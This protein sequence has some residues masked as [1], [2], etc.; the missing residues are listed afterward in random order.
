MLFFGRPLSLLENKHPI[1]QRNIPIPLAFLDTLSYTPIIS[2]GHKWLGF[3]L[4]L[5]YPFRESLPKATPFLQAAPSR[6][7]TLLQCS[8]AIK[9]SLDRARKYVICLM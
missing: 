8:H 3:L 1:R 2:M 5:G 7:N 4:G 6:L 9:M